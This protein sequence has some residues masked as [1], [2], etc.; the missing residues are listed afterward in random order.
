LIGALNEGQ[1]H[2][3]GLEMAP[4]W[5]QR[6]HHDG[7]ESVGHEHSRKAIIKWT[8]PFGV[9][10]PEARNASRRPKNLLSEIATFE[11]VKRLI[12]ANRAFDGM[13]ALHVISH[14]GCR[15]YGHVLA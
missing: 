3:I 1:N 9:T 2:A 12:S 11:R 8:L 13:K 4:E 15:F 5:H 14:S 6:M 7:D 10:G